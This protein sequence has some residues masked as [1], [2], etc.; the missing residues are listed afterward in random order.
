MQVS[1]GNFGFSIV[2][3]FRRLVKGKR[4]FLHGFS[5]GFSM[6]EFTGRE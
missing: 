5:M 1:N 2:C 3:L 6:K 4:V